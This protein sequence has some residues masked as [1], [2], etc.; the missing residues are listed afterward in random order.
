[1]T[2][3]LRVDQYMFLIIYRSFLLRMR[4][5]VNK[6]V[7]KIKTHILCLL[8]FFENCVV[9]EI[10]WK[11]IKKPDRPQMTIWSMSISR[12]VPKATNSHFRNV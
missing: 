6:F 7:Q 8:F 2:G 10:I 12:W 11:N 1:M 3:R 4:N 9:C 5:A